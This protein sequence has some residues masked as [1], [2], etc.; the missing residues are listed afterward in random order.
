GVFAAALRKALVDGQVDLAVHSLK[1]LPAVQPPELVIAA[2]PTREDPADVLVGSTLA[3]LPTGARVGTGSP[4][5]ATQLTA[6]RPDLHVVEVRG[7]VDTRIAAVESGRLDAVVLARAG[8]ARLGRLA[9]IAE[10]LDLL[11][12]PGQGALAVECRPE[13][14]SR[15]AFLDDPDSRLAVTAERA[16]L[17]GLAAGCS[18]PVGALAT[19]LGDTLQVRALVGAGIHVERTTHDLDQ[20]G[21]DRLGHDVAADLLAQGADVFLA[22]NNPMGQH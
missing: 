6:R 18:T 16:V 21:A 17:V 8:L 19:R 20:A 10:V 13:H 5:R 1:D 15:F 14:A 7:N 2:V 3:D 9:A 4:R 12:A 22:D 11:P